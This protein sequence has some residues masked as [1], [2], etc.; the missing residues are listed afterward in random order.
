MAVR[1]TKRKLNK[2]SVMFNGTSAQGVG[3][4]LAKDRNVREVGEFSSRE[5]RDGIGCHLLPPL[6]IDSVVLFYFLRRNSISGR[7]V[8]SRGSSRLTPVHALNLYRAC[9]VQHSR[10][11]PTYIM[12]IDNKVRLLLDA[13]FL[14]NKRGAKCNI[15]IP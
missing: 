14:C 9:W 1:R 5:S 6:R 3:A 10:C 7:S 11:S 12:Y 13:S 2:L 8:V 15:I 4:F